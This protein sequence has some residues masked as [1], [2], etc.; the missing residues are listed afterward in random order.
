MNNIVHAFLCRHSDSLDAIFLVL[1]NLLALREEAF[2]DGGISSSISDWESGGDF[3][4][5]NGSMPI[6][7]SLTG[8][9]RSLF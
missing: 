4:P 1:N 3:R 9:F 2:K 5:D 8:N 7:T 6:S